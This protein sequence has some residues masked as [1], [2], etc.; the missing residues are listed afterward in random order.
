VREAFPAALR[1]Y[2]WIEG[3]NL[4]VER[5]YASGDLE[6]L[7]QLASELVALNV[8]VIYATTGRAG[9]AA[10]SATN[11]I[12]IVT[13]SG[14]MVRQGLVASLAR[15]G[16]NVTGQ[17]VNSADVNV[18]TKRVQFLSDV[19]SLRPLRVAVFGCGAAGASGDTRENWAWAATESTARILKLHLH[20]Y[21]PR[22]LAAIDTALKDASKR[23]GALLLF[24][25]S[26]FN[27]LDHSVF[28]DHQL[29]AM[30]PFEMFAHRGGLMAYGFDEI[31]FNQRHAWYIDR[32]FR[33]ANPADLPVEQ[34]KFKFVINLTA[35][36][37]LRLKVPEALL[38]R[39]DEVIR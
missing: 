25:C 31:L 1:G 35:A 11:R 2:G 3:Q 15:P 14:D 38:L 7:P 23:T 22:T 37:R 34:A 27:A 5:R 36:S 17:H 32:I 9:L 21:S 29:P 16:G 24:D 6:R 26:Y 30:Y 12:P 33:G 20:P 39:A 28:L 13:N 19:V 10:K 18:V 8:D 4:N